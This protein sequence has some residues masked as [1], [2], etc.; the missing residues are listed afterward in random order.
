MQCGQV[1]LKRAFT[2]LCVTGSA[3]LPRHVVLT[4]TQHFA[5]GKAR[6]EVCL[7]IKKRM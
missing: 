1:C 2:G 3:T 4:R 7:G 5:G 6:S